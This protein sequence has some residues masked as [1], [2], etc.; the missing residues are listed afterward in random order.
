MAAVGYVLSERRWP[1]WLMR[2]TDGRGRMSEIIV[3]RGITDG[4][5]E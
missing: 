5:V 1:S 2:V 4:V 3:Q